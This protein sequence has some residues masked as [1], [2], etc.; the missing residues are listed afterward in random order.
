MVLHDL[1]CLYVQDKVGK[2]EYATSTARTVSSLLVNVIRAMMDLGLTDDAEALRSPQFGEFIAQ[3]GKRFA[4]STYRNIRSALRGF[5]RWLADQGYL[6]PRI[7]RTKRYC[8]A[9]AWRAP[10]ATRQLAMS[11]LPLL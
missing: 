6:W 10:A 7:A 4:H 2:G 1:L 9:V 3:Y 5:E 8:S 11:P